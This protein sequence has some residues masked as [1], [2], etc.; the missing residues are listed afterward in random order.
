MKN[1]Y[2]ISV[3]TW[4][5]IIAFAAVPLAEL[6]KFS[7]M[8]G[9][10]GDARLNN[11]FL[12]NIY[13]V[14]SGHGGSLIN[15]RFFYP[16]PY[17]LGFSDNLFGS[18]PAYL[19]PRWLIGE[20]DTA[21][22]I[23]Y[24][25]GYLVNYI[26]TY[27]ALRKLRLSE[28]GAAVGALIFTFALPVTSQAA[29]A[30]LL[31]RFGVP[32]SVVALISFLE[33]KDW[34]YLVLSGAWL[35]WQFYCTIYIGVFL[36]MLLAAILALYFINTQHRQS[37][38]GDA[39][40]EYASS[41]KRSSTGQKIGLAIS[42]CVLGALIVILFYPYVKVSELYGA[43]RGWSEIT[44]MLPRLQ[45]Y[46]LSDESWLWSWSSQF[47]GFSALPMRHEHQMFIGLAPMVLAVCG[48]LFGRKEK[49]GI[50]F[51]LLSSSLML[52]VL[53]T[54]YFG[55]FSLW[56][57]FYKLPL[58]SA[59]RGVSRVVVV[60]LFPIGYLA[61]SFVDVLL[62]RH[63]AG[64]RLILTVLVPALILEFAFIS[65]LSSAKED[66]RNR[67]S[68]AES[69]IPV[70][71]PKDAVLFFAQ[72]QGAFDADE[73][74]AMWASL[75]SGHDTL[76]GFSGNYPGGY[77][78]VYGE[79]C[80][81]LPRRIEAYLSFIGKPNDHDLY[82]KLINRVVPLG[83]TNCNPLWNSQPLTRSHSGV[84]SHANTSYTAEQ[85]HALSLQYGGKSEVSGQRYIDVKIINSSD[86][87]FSAISDV[88]T[89]IRVSWRY[90]DANGKPLSGWEARKDLPSDIPA[91]GELDI[92]LPI[93]AGAVR[94]SQMLEVTLVQETVFWAHD[95]GMK[96]LLMK[97][98]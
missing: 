79:D 10:L 40:S 49:S 2:K 41:L 14:L 12:E 52:L 61:A 69:K 58:L 18:A 13:H 7:V 77:D 57:L 9:L 24:L 55:G 94:Q 59:I 73:L 46:F 33:R 43:K 89:P 98:N 86:E 64:R 42:V 8:P 53:V 87:T 80:S 39:I 48:F 34:R 38:L 67:L 4:L 84:Q 6:E 76:N 91:N 96:P 21:Y 16:F 93:T 60:L 15:L 22:Q 88:N 51:P 62:E 3:A 90:R 27:Y 66:W 28:T 25:I 63:S 11:Y 56:I 95:I 26:A 1:K 35:V 5:F 47:R 83:F 92:A 36:A 30:Q 32:L 74:D 75:E 50:A 71:L 31:Y 45:S 20:S 82:T 37:T 54:T 44:Q 72:T 81:Q 29:H 17:I 70:N 85:F 23:W 68:A 19:I 65:P 97:L 78:V